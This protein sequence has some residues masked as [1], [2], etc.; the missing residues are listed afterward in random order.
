MSGLEL[1]AAA[2]GVIAVW[3]T[4]KQNPWCWPIG[5]VMV[6]LYSWIFF[7]VKLYSDMLLQVVYA[8]LQL[9]GWWQW[10][11]AGAQHQGRKVTAL[12]ARQVVTGLAIGA[13]GWFARA[14]VPPSTL[15]M[16]EMA[17][18]E[19]FDNA[20]RIPGDSLETVS[21]AQIKSQGLYAYTAINAPRGLN[22]RIYHA[23]RKDGQEVDR[24]ALDIKGGREAGYRAWTHKQNFPS[25]PSGKWQVQ[26]LTEAGQVIGTLRF[27]VTP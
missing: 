11:R 12:T 26:V 5:L 24:I 17:V 9:Y 6:L 21:V 16:T 14:W 18:T 7:E 8:A 20:Q 10:T 19:S 23:W 2:L 25:D 22:E 3:L 15:W 27:E 13:V 1:F 4:V